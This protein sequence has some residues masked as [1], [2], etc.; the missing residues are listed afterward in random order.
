MAQLG[1]GSRLTRSRLGVR[2]AAGGSRG[3]PPRVARQSAGAARCAEA[4]QAPVSG[5][6]RLIVDYD[7]AAGYDCEAEELIA[8]AVASVPGLD[9]QARPAHWLGAGCFEVMLVGADLAAELEVL[10]LEDE[11]RYTLAG[12]PPSFEPA[13]TE[14]A[15]VEGVV[16]FSRLTTGTL[17]DVAKEVLP[18]LVGV[19]RRCLEARFSPVEPEE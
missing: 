14:A 6:L 7:D 15:Y 5:G 13:R 2:D 10:A 19:Q 11:L 8:A 16:I 4:A 3:W 12:L 17:P 18:V 1:M 9:T